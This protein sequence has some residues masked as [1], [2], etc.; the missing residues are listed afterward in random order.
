MLPTY[1]TNITGF[2]HCCCGSSF[3]NDSIKAS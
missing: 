2:F 1:T 3:T